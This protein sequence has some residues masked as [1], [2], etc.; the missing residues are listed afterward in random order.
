VV[1]FNISDSIQIVCT[2][3]GSQSQHNPRGAEQPRGKSRRRGSWPILDFYWY[4]E[5]DVIFWSRLVNVWVFWLR[6]V[7]WFMNVSWALSYLFNFILNIWLFIFYI[8]HVIC[9]KNDQSQR[10]HYSLS[11]YP[12][13]GVGRSAPLSGRPTYILPTSKYLWCFGVS[14]ILTKTFIC[15]LK[16][17]YDDCCQVPLSL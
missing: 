16:K 4:L 5:L 1:V 17:Y 6:L 3:L 7:F 11:R 14:F 13:F 10:S 9:P 2:Y 8:Y 12:T 15:F